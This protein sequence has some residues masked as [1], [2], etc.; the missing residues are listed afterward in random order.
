MTARQSHARLKMLNEP[1][2]LYAAYSRY[3]DWVKIGFSSKLGDRLEAINRQYAAFAPFSLIGSARSTWRAEQQVHRFLEPLRQR[4]VAA[5]RELYPAIPTVISAIKA[6]LEGRER[7]TFTADQMRDLRAWGR[8][9]A[10]HPLNRTPALE[11]FQIF[12]AE[13]RTA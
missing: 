6:M 5:T 3:C 10:E 4:R 2:H 7:P 12:A 1:G 13:R 9:M 8:K 11:A